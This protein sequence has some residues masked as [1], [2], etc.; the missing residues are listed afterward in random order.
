[1]GAG[2][3]D[4]AADLFADADFVEADALTYS[5]ANYDMIRGAEDVQTVYTPQGAR[6]MRVLP[7][8]VLV[9]DFTAGHPA[10]RAT[11]TLGGV[12]YR[13]VDRRTSSTGKTYRLF[14]ADQY[15]EGSR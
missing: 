12:T 5:G 6:A 1:M 7:V 9:A 8:D 14:L 15:G 13:I 11:V 2:D 10:L 3:F 4:I